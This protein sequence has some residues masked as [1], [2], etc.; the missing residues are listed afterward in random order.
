VD[1]VINGL[2]MGPIR[3]RIFFSFV[4]GV[5]SGLRRRGL[6]REREI[7]TTVRT[8]ENDPTSVIVLLCVCSAVGTDHFC[9]ITSF[10]FYNY[11]RKEKIR[12]YWKYLNQ[13]YD[14]TLG[15]RHN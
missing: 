13:A 5:I 6:I 1:S 12:Q 15:R 11:P 2:K 8:V 3:E 4:Y 9:F 10:L 7:K 14:Q